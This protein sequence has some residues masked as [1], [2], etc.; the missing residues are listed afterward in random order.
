MIRLL[1]LSYDISLDT[2]GI[3]N[4]GYILSEYLAKKMKL[5]IIC[6]SQS[7]PPCSENIKCYKVDL[8]Q[9]G[10]AYFNKKAEEIAIKLNSQERFDFAL[11]MTGAFGLALKNLKRKAGIPYGSLV[12]GSEL[13]K[14]HFVLNSV[15]YND[16]M[17]LLK[18]ILIVRRRSIKVWKSTLNTLENADILFSNTNYTR[19]LLGRYVNNKRVVVIH[20]PIYTIPEVQMVENRSHILFSV[21][22]L[23]SRKG[24]QFV[25]QA[26]PLICGVIPDVKYIIAG[27][28]EMEPKLKS[29]VKELGLEERVVFMGR[30]DDETKN[31]LMQECGAFITTSYTE[32]NPMDVESFGIVYVE[33][34]A[35]GK[36]V[37]A[38]NTGGV[39]EAV[40]DGETGI[41][42]EQK[43]IR[44]I[45][46]AVIKVFGSD[47][48][49]DPQKCIDNAKRN[50]ISVISESYY[51]EID[52]F[53]KALNR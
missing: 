2:G 50:H 31:Q 8:E 21:G 36:Y 38:A 17:S 51:N 49:Y 1:V 35:Y 29:L 30:I 39:G 9:N 37:I 12:H 53:L 18:W 7:K 52:T 25:I 45:A 34:N 20:P 24:Y 47:F 42:V 23:T 27:S 3:Q 28:G 4:T 14:P 11:S 41:L 40:I 16:L 19:S 10:W 32:P 44:Q 48:K 43:N 13:F 22:R 46:D 26:L 33:A 15:C 5:T 6:G